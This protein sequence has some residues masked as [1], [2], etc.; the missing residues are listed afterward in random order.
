MTLARD[1]G[2]I[3]SHLD[4]HRRAWRDH[5]WGKGIDA[6]RPGRTKHQGDEGMTEPRALIRSNA[7][8]VIVNPLAGA[9]RHYTQQLE[10]M[11]DG[12]A[13]SVAVLSI[14]EP[15]ISGK[16]RLTWLWEYAKT[17]VKARRTRRSG[18]RVVVTWP[19][20][21]H[22]DRIVAPLLSGRQTS[23]VM[24]DPRPLVRAVGYGTVVVKIANLLAPKRSLIVHSALAAEHLPGSARSVVQLPHPL[25]SSMTS[26]V[27]PASP[28]VR[29]LG[30][31][32]PDRDVSLLESLATFL[33]SSRL[34]IVGRGWPPVPGWIVRDEFVSERELDGLIRTS[35]SVLIPYRRYYQSGIAA[36]AIEAAV[37]VIGRSDELSSMTGGDYPFLLRS[38]ANVRDWVDMIRS[39]ID[40]EPVVLERV[41]AVAT[42]RA[43]D[44]W[45]TWAR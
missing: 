37:P 42:T 9:L 11:F 22:F 19:V 23:V 20:L 38:D 17:L 3:G 29:V 16:S 6:L 8:L 33:P 7:D 43:L 34:E 45:K 30:Q 31:W 15:S 35:S 39:A 13:I 4:E 36:R 12:S 14:P 1:R 21:G 25:L 32:K 41:R 26:P 24:H 18:G 28:V 40:S 2:S 5:R 27:R 44:G 10:Q